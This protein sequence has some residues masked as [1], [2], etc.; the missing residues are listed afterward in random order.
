MAISDAR[1][2]ANKK[3]DDKNKA[4][5][6]YLHKRSNAKSFILKNATEEDLKNILEYVEQRKNDLKNC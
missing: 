4:R 5:L 3:W 1:K 6:N 2:K